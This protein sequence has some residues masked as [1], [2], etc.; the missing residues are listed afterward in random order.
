MSDVEKQILV[1][2]AAIMASLS[3]LLCKAESHMGSQQGLLTAVNH[4]SD[5]LGGAIVVKEVEFT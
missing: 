5:L 4:T 2:Q 3:E 1:N